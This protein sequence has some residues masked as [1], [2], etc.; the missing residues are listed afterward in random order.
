MP[1]VE[2]CSKEMEKN[3][4]YSGSARLSAGSR[5]IRTVFTAVERNSD[6]LLPISGQ[7]KPLP[8]G[9]AN[10]CWSKQLTLDRPVH[11]QSAGKLLLS[12]RLNGPAFSL[13]ERPEPALLVSPRMTCG[14]DPVETFEDFAMNKSEQEFGHLSVHAAG[15]RQN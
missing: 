6:G 2:D 12:S 4:T 9:V 10:Y 8:C 3:S 7:D 14:T 15:I 11:V 13:G 1:C 5:A